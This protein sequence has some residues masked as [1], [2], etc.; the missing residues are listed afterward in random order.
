VSA[1]TIAVTGASGFVCANIALFLAN[2]G[3]RVFACDVQPAPGALREAWARFGDRV[4]PLLF[5]VTRPQGWAALDDEPLDAVINGAAVTPYGHDPNPAFSSRVNLWGAIEGLDYLRRR[6]GGRFVYISSSGVYG[7][8]P[9]RTPLREDRPLST[10]SSY[11][12]AKRCAEAYV[13]LYRAQYGVDACSA[14]LAAPYGP[15][16]R[17]TG[18]RTRMGAVHRML[19]AALTGKPIYVGGTGVVRDWTH[20]AD[21]AG[22]LSHL[23][24]AAAVPYDLFNISNGMPVAFSRVVAAARKAVPEARFTRRRNGAV[25]AEMSPAERRAPVDVSRLREAGFTGTITVE[26]GVAEYAAWMR[27]EGA[28]VLREEGE[29]SGG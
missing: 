10:M 22:A 12:H 3:H 26:E 27:N 15:W 5:D 8:V 24:L 9:G 1:K 13:S 17:P 18:V 28:F 23:A 20:V 11:T 14:R 4:R 19:V 25:V 21:I 6:G 16:E 2:R 29:Q 7:T